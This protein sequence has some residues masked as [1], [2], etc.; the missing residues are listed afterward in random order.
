VTLAVRQ[1]DW[2][3]GAMIS[4]SNASGEHEPCDAADAA[5]HNG[6]SGIV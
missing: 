3:A 4:R 6:P 1:T 5:A 2:F